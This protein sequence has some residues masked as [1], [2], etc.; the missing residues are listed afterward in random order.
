MVAQSKKRVPAFFEKI[1]KVPGS[2]LA[3]ACGTPGGA[4][5]VWP[6]TPWLI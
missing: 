4:L 5:V 6:L 3:L 2:R 1:I